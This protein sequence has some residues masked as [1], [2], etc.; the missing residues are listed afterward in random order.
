M[1]GC[2]AAAVVS[3]EPIATDPVRGVL[4]VAE[5]PNGDDDG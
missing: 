4:V 5:D 2:G 1:E 3:I